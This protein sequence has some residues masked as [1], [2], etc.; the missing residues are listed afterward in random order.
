METI[1][2]PVGLDTRGPILCSWRAAFFT[3]RRA[4]ALSHRDK[5][6]RLDLSY[7][8]L[9][10]IRAKSRSRCLC[11]PFIETAADLNKGIINDIGRRGTEKSVP[12]NNGC[13]AIFLS[14]NFGLSVL[15]SAAMFSNTVVT[16]MFSQKKKQ[17]RGRCPALR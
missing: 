17:K 8:L 10:F 1:R 5:R 11:F 6:P 13:S 2:R 7:A 16:W 4:A 9:R 12:K 3:P 15:F 14:T